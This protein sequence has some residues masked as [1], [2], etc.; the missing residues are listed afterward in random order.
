MLLFD[1]GAHFGVFSLAAAH[2]GG[3][4]VA[5]DPSP[6]AARMIEVEAA[7]N[8]CAGSI[9]ILQTAVSEV[10]AV[11]MLSSGVFSN[12]YFQAA[13][14]RSDTKE[15]PATTIDQL[16]TR[17]GKP[18]HIKIDVEGHEAEVLRGGRETLQRFAPLLFLELHNAII[19]SAGG[20]PVMVIQ[21][22]LSLGYEL[23]GL[24]GQQAPHDALTKPAISRFVATPRKA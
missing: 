3:K 16:T 7:L 1:I 20:D 9:H 2:F 10:G 6:I 19:T 22:V 13:K 14:G 11:S 21:E 5:A 24:D 8:Q 4:A 12:G 17:F 18:T 15:T 23:F